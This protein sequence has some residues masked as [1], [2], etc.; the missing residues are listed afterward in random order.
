MTDPDQLR[1]LL[2]KRSLQPLSGLAIQTVLDMV[3][4]GGG[5]CMRAWRFRASL[6]LCTLVG[7]QAAH[8]QGGSGHVMSGSCSPGHVLI[9]GHDTP[10]HAPMHNGCA[11]PPHACFGADGL[12]AAYHAAAALHLG[13]LS[14][15]LYPC[16]PYAAM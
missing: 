8:A 11:F 5:A 7:R 10:G 12:R 1:K 6:V 4:A 2:V 9:L 13:N 15:A 16:P 3:A 14:H